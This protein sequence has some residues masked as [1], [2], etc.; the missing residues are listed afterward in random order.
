MNT[1]KIRKIQALQ[2]ATGIGDMLNQ[3]A[4]MEQLS[5]F[6]DENRLR[7][8]AYQLQGRELDLKDLEYQN[9]TKMLPL[10]Q[11]QMEA[12]N[13]YVK[14]LANELGQRIQQ[15]EKLFPL[16]YQGAEAELEGKKTANKWTADQEDRWNKTY[17]L[18]ERQTKAGEKSVNLRIQQQNQAL[19]LGLMQLFLQGAS[20]TGS[21][22][23][24]NQNPVMDV[25]KSFEKMRVI[26]QV[27]LGDNYPS[28]WDMPSTS[29]GSLQNGSSPRGVPI[30]QLSPK[31]RQKVLR[32]TQN[33]G[34]NSW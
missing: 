6:D 8:L 25:L 23:D 19:L 2:Q 32:N 30:D 29:T 26:P 34:M 28:L 31:Q 27:Q 22:R 7:E 21:F 12:R 3:M 17:D 33:R 13:A 20:R 16:R 10:Q 4:Q 5:Q 9:R 11:Q 14:Q 18:Q 24:V 15:G 1:E